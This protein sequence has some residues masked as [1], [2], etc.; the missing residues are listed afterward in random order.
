MNGEPPFVVVLGTAQDGGCPQAGCRCD[1]CQAARADSSFRRWPACLGI[2]DP[3][4]GEYWLVD[5]TPR[6]PEQVEALRDTVSEAIAAVP[7]GILLT[8]AHMGHYLGLMQLGQEVMGA[9]DVPVWAMPRMRLFLSENS[10]WRELIE[11][12]HI[13][14]RHLVAGAS[15]EL[16]TRVQVTPLVVPHRGDLSETV[17]FQVRLVKGF[18]GCPI[19]TTGMTRLKIT[20]RIARWPGWTERSLMKPNCQ[21]VI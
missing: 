20:S 18:Y 19:L 17:A 14:V 12:K 11:A 13:D 3:E 7:D 5:A 1:A 9:A 15:C 6:F 4:R 16:N 21:A 8:H 2:V 10:P